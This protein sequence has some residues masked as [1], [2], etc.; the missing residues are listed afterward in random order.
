[1]TPTEVGFINLARALKAWRERVILPLT[2]WEDVGVGHAARAMRSR[3]GPDL[4][5]RVA[6]TLPALPLLRE[7]VENKEALKLRGLDDPETS[8][9]LRRPA[10]P[11]IDEEGIGAH[12]PF[13]PL[14]LF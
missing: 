8:E 12:D 5:E 3:P 11:V 13:D 10:P 4:L 2:C 14:E 6:A 1:E 7:R 9:A